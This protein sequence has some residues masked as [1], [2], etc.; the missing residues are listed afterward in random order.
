MLRGRITDSILQAAGGRD[1]DL[2]G[3]IVRAAVRTFVES[4]ADVQRAV[5][6][7]A[8]LMEEIGARQARRGFD[9]ADLS[10]SFRTAL[11]ATQ[12]GLTLVVGDLV[13]RDTLVQ[14]REDLVAY[15]TELTHPHPCRAR[16]RPGAGSSRLRSSAAAGSSGSPSA[17]TPAASCDKLLTAD[18]IDPR[19]PVRAIVSL[20]TAIPRSIRDHPMTLGGPSPCEVLVPDTW[21]LDQL[22]AQLDG[23]ATVGPPTPLLEAT[24]AITLARQA[25]SLLRDGSVVDP[26]ALVPCTDMLSDLVARANPM[27][28]R[29]M[30]DKHLHEFHAMSVQRRVALGG[31]LLQTLENG[32]PMSAAARDLGISRQTAFSRMKALKAM[33]GESLNDPAQ[34][35]ELIVAMRAAL[36]GWRKELHRR[37]GT[38][39][40]VMLLMGL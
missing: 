23:Q 19:Q 10:A 15:L 30:I 35:L 28:A 31:L 11:V 33:F 6:S 5:D 32:Q 27:L 34:R 2:L 22:S 3:E 21:D 7:I 26:R 37:P 4:R 1:D 29:L 38:P 36:L 20:S 9:A 40:S 8:P 39:R 12:R 18:G 16:A 13:N 17:P 14:L 24:E 25:A